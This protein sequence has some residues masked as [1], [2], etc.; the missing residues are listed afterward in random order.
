VPFEHT[1]VR[2]AQL[3][4][5]VPQQ[6]GEFLLAAWHQAPLSSQAQAKPK[7]SHQRQRLAWL[8]GAA[9]LLDHDFETLKRLVCENLDSVV[10]AASR[11]ERVNSWMRPSLHTWKGHI[12]QETWNLSL[13]YHNHRRDKSGKR[14]GQAPLEILTGTPWPGQ[15]DERCIPQVNKQAGGQA[16]ATRRPPAPL[17]L[18]GSRKDEAIPPVTSLDQAIWDN[19]ADADHL[20]EA[21]QAKA[22]AQMAQARLHTRRPGG[23]QPPEGSEHWHGIIPEV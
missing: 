17:Q 23:M 20:L 10:R 13:F 1:Q 18:V 5:A 15:W 6:A 19:P 7:R 2:H 16:N 21:L 4:D 12:P 11:V 8:A 3:L 14:T 9:G 22:A